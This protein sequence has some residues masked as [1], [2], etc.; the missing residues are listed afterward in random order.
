MY[1]I[2][3]NRMLAFVSIITT[4]IIIITLIFLTLFI[5]ITAT[6]IPFGRPLRGQPPSM[7]PHRLSGLLTSNMSL[8]TWPSQ[9]AASTQATTTPTWKV[10]ITTFQ[11]WTNTITGLKTPTPVGGI[12]KSSSHPPRGLS[13]PSF[14]TETMTLLMKRVTRTGLSCLFNTGGRI[15]RELGR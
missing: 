8:S 13:P 5:S 10:N 15:P 9:L 3:L 1:N 4:I 7:S 6:S 12:L 2:M 11:V 14:P